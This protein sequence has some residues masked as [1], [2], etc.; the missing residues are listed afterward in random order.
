MGYTFHVNVFLMLRLLNL[1]TYSYRLLF[2]VDALIPKIERS[3]LSGSET[4]RKLL[5]TRALS[6]PVGFTVDLSEQRLY[7][8]DY[9][10]DSIESVSYTGEHRQFLRRRL[11]TRL[12]D[13]AVYK[14][15]ID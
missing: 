15:N 10:R 8:T 12:Y 3:D 2:W 7:W 14:V 11:T 13:I 9:T 1:S 6:W 5:V 4:S